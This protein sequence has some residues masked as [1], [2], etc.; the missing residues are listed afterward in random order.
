MPQE[1]PC[2]SCPLAPH[3]GSRTIGTYRKKKDNTNPMI[4]SLYNQITYLL[5]AGVLV[6]PLC[7]VIGLL[8]KL[9]QTLFTLPEEHLFVQSVKRVIQVIKFL[10]FG[11][12]AVVFITVGVSLSW[13]LGILAGVVLYFS[14]FL[15]VA[16]IAGPEAARPTSNE[17]QTHEKEE[18]FSGSGGTYGGGGAS[19]SW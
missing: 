16:A 8:G 11:L 4:A 6:G 2:G 18:N 17:G 19:G 15:L 9:G 3:C 14:D 5:V 1:A 12:I 13:L 7:W 10:K